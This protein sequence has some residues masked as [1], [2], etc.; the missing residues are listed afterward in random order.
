MVRPWFPLYLPNKSTMRTWLSLRCFGHR[1]PP[2]TIGKPTAD[3]L[4]R[5]GNGFVIDDAANVESRSCWNGC[6]PSLLY[7][8]FQGGSRTGGWN[9]ALPPLFGQPLSVEV[10]TPLSD[11]SDAHCWCWRTRISVLLF[12]SKLIK[13]IVEEPR[14]TGVGRERRDGSHSK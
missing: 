9:A 11:S 10:S 13:L 6:P 7:S 1:S 3:K 12:K 2:P 4:I 8:T 5:E 14:S